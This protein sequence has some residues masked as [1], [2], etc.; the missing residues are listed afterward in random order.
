MSFFFSLCHLSYPES[1][2]GHCRLRIGSRFSA[3]T[4]ANIAF[5]FEWNQEI[6]LNTKNIQD[7]CPSTAI[8]CYK[9]GFNKH[10][11]NS[12]YVLST[13]LNAEMITNKCET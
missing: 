2:L 4:H 9:E 13:M 8:H 5:G 10:L 6:L 7:L 11:L 1:L 12:N 3:P